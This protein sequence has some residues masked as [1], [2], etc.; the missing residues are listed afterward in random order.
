MTALAYDDPCLRLAGLQS[1]LAG[2]FDLSVERGTILA[3][4]GASGSGKSLFLRMLVDLD[5][6][7]GLVELDGVARAAIA[8]PIWRRQIAY[9]PAETGWWGETVAD[10]LV[11]GTQEA[12]RKLAQ[13]FGLRPGLLEEPVSRLSTGE[14]QRLGLVRSFVTAPKVLLLDEPTAAL[15]P[16]A[17]LEIERWLVD[18]AGAGGTVI[19]VSHNLAQVHR[20]ASRHLV[21]VDR[22][23]E[24]AP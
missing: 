18:Y 22:R 9:V 3:I 15:D 17:T 21:M 13:R 19:I 5:V 20:I 6:N 4:T 14:R 10:H 24:P 12:A 1:A 23:L 2:P 16:D 8:A 11:P 7:E